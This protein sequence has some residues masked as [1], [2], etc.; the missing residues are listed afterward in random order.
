MENKIK[1]LKSEDLTCIIFKN[2]IIYRSRERGVKPLLYYLD[3]GINLEGYSSVDKVIGKAA[4]FL[5]IML[6]I[7]RIHA[8]II[9]KAAYNLFLKYKIDITYDILVDYIENRKKDGK[10]PLESTVLSIEDPKEA[11]LKI[12]NKVKELN[13][14]V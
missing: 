5:Y 1:M 8:L 11:L 9:S 12:R 7:S 2:D 6:G 3:N 13:R 4:A 14:N 10:C